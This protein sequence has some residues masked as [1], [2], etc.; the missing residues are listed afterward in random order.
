MRLTTSSISERVDALFQILEDSACSDYIGESVNQ[1]EHALQC[2]HFARKAGASDEAVIASLVHD[3][4]HLLDPEAPSMAGLGV[5]D[6]ERLGADYLRA[7]GFSETVARLV[8][9]HVQAKRYLT[10]AKPAYAA[11]LSE[12]SKGTLAWQGGPMSA[13]EAAAFERDAYYPQMLQVRSWDERAKVVGLEVAPLEDYRAAIV[14][15]LGLNERSEDT[16]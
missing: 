8:E 14:A 1:L 3:I 2:A 6:H 9:G 4:G 10:F 11:R 5:I 16:S 12:A 15:H 7:L 13:A